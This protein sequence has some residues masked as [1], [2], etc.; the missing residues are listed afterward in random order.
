M[1]LELKMLVFGNLR[2]LFRPGNGEEVKETKYMSSTNM[3]QGFFL[4]S[5]VVMLLAMPTFAQDNVAFPPDTIEGTMEA[6]EF[7]PERDMQYFKQRG[8]GLDFVTTSPGNYLL[9]SNVYSQEVSQE[10]AEIIKEKLTKA[11]NLN[12]QGMVYVYFEDAKFHVARMNEPADPFNTDPI[13][14]AIHIS[15]KKEVAD[16]SGNAWVFEMTADQ[17]AKLLERINSTLE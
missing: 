2:I 12:D 11:V 14:N 7:N 3:K 8:E 4:L 1:I 10:R 13:I 9:V 6:A 15:F 5:G 16:E 17:G